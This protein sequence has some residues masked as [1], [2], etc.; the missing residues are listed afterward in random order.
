VRGALCASPGASWSPLQPAASRARSTL[1]R[2][3]APTRRRGLQSAARSRPARTRP[4]RAVSGCQPSSERAL[5]ETR[6]AREP[7][8]GRRREPSPTPRDRPT[9]GF[10]FRTR[11]ISTR[12]I[13]R[14][15]GRV[16]VAGNVAGNACFHRCFQHHSP[17]PSRLSRGSLGT[18]RP[19][20]LSGPPMGAVVLPHRLRAGRAR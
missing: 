3:A 9:H 20:R 8:R 15:E 18:P 19:N 12:T 7:R 14:R 5:P 11:N 6:P 4:H 10:S 16:D 13:P 2:P 1:R 17:N